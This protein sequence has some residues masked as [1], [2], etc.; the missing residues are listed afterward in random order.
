M[1]GED[2]NH[3][4]I[5]ILVDKLRCASMFSQPLR[6]MSGIAIAVILKDMSSCLL[7]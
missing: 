7:P 2:P 6:T 1:G 3:P 5:S 4:E